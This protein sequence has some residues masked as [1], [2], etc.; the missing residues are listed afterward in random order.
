MPNGGSFHAMVDDVVMP[1]TDILFPPYCTFIRELTNNSVQLRRLMK[2][3]RYQEEAYNG[4]RRKAPCERTRRKAPC[5][6]TRRKGV[7]RRARAAPRRA[8]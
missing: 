5:E 6:R 4:A 1:D 3:R 7:P 2:P 8:Y